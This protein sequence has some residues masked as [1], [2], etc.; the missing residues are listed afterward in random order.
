M[1]TLENLKD[2][3]D[4]QEQN[5]PIVIAS[6]TDLLEVIQMAGDTYTKAEIDAKI[7][8]IKD[9]ISSGIKLK[10]VVYGFRIRVEQDS[11]CSVS[12]LEMPLVPHQHL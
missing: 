3:F 8:E 11:S 5:N 12:Y 6:L 9:T 7:Q 1:I 2:Y 10:D 4:L